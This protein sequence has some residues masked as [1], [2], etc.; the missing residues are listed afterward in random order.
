MEYN[1]R[2]QTE[3]LA[4]MELNITDFKE[5]IRSSESFRKGYSD[6]IAGESVV[7]DGM[8]GNAPLA[9]SAVLAEDSHKLILLICPNIGEVDTVAEDL[10]LFTDIPV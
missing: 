4:S 6:L 8:I 1:G 10:R 5:L 3:D 7:F 2:S 9:I